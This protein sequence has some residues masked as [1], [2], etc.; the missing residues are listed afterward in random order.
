MAERRTRIEGRRVHRKYEWSNL[1]FFLS[2]AVALVLFVMLVFKIYSTPEVVPSKAKSAY[3]VIL[4]ELV[5][6][7]SNNCIFYLETEVA[8][9]SRRYNSV[10]EIPAGD[11]GLIKSLFQLQGVMGVQIN[12]RSIVLYKT[13]SAHWQEIRPGAREAITKYVKKPQ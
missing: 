13:P 5:P 4:R 1:L 3:S 6:P 9:D 10:T 8:G 12:Q 7:S 11:S 2:V